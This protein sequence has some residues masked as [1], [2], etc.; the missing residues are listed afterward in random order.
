L[1]CHNI[2]IRLKWE[3]GY[4][5][6]INSHFV[7]YHRRIT[8]TGI[9]RLQHYVFPSENRNRKTGCSHGWQLVQNNIDTLVKLRF[10]ET[11]PVQ[12]Q[13]NPVITGIGTG[14]TF[15]KIYITQFPTGNMPGLDISG[16]EN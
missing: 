3:V 13:L 5:N 15:P 12:L 2:T 1:L 14:S 10:C 11:I 8:N 4:I 16:K 9:R 6:F 7:T